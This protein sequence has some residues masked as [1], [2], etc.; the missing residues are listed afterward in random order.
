MGEAHNYEYTI[1]DEEP[2][3]Y[4][5]KKKKYFLKWP[6]QREVVASAGRICALVSFTLSLNHQPVSLYFRP[7]YLFSLIWLFG[8]SYLVSR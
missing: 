8:Q 3:P 2:K 4:T 6:K 1:Y 5:K 7:S